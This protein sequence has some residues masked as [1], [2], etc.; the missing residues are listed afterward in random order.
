MDQEA[1]NLLSA[2]PLPQDPLYYHKLAIAQERLGRR[3]EALAALEKGYALLESG[4]LLSPEDSEAWRALSRQMLDLVRYRLEHPDYLTD[5][6]YAALMT[7]AF[8][9][10]QA[11][12]GDGFVRF[13]V[14][15]MLQVLEAERRYKD[16]YLLTKKY[17]FKNS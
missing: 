7:D 16:A 6:I 17:F 13:H 8:A 11:S 4:E 14:P 10:I 5:G 9:A 12:L 3:E 15:Y 1:R 2:S